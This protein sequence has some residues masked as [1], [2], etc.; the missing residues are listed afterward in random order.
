MEDPNQEREAEIKSL[1]DLVVRR[2]MDIDF[3]WSW[4][5]G[6]AFYGVGRAW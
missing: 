6:V 1:I 4:P 2:T 5:A 3:S